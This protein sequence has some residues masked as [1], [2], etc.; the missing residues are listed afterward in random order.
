M[1]FYHATRLFTLIALTMTVSI[2][3][4]ANDVIGS[5]TSR[6]SVTLGENVT[7]ITIS[8]NI[9]PYF[10]GD[11]IQAPEDASARVR[12]N[13]NDGFVT[14]GS[15][16]EATVSTGPGYYVVADGNRIDFEIELG[17]PYVIQMDCYVVRPH[18]IQNVASGQKISGSI[19][20]D[21]SG[22]YVLGRGG[23]IDV[24]VD[25]TYVARQYS[26]QERQRYVSIA[27]PDRLHVLEKD[28]RLEGCGAA[29]LIAAIPRTC[30]IPGS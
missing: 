19:I 26:A 5:M 1:F 20:R 21:D 2:Q 29:G 8:D 17:V 23:R 15:S 18:P 22:T 12:L 11:L 10:N 16:T 4:H 3:A 27:Q 28:D 30:P 25:G 6:G 13:N 9:H 24:T 14:V 7:S